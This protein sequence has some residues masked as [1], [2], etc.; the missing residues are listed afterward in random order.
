MIGRL[1]LV[2][3]CSLVLAATAAAAR[4]EPW[5]PKERFNPADQE[6]ARSFRVQ[7][8]DLGAGDWR[9]ETVGGENTSLP[10]CKNPDL[11]DLVLTGKAQNPNFSRN[12]SLVASEGE[13]WASE[14]DAAK[15]WRR[16]T[17]FDFA[18]C[19]PAAMRKSFRG[20]SGVSLTI[21]SSGPMR[22]A[23][24]AP[25]MFTY[26]ISFRVKGPRAAVQGRLSLYAFARGRADASLMVMSFGRPAQP[27]PE[28]LER[29]L[30]ALVAGRLKSR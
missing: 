12:G 16:S 6:L 8:D 7:R 4:R 18:T 2:L 3:I 30:A 26:R 25:R 13:V 22:M 29:K 27:I 5:E 1:G 19:L 20:Q 11:S 23:K 14:R 10:G 24:L 17:G 15:A 21:L 9:V 28:S